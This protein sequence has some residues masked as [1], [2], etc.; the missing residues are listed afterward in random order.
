MGL[1]KF[2]SLGI[3]QLKSVFDEAARC[4]DLDGKPIENAYMTDLLQAVIDRGISIASVPVSGGWIEVDTVDDLNSDVT[5][6]RI[7]S[8][9]ENN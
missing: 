6:Q 2:S 9:D 7:N 4:G 3:K 1:M 5:N 8:I